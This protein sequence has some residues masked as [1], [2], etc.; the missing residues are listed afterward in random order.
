MWSENSAGRAV[1]LLA[2]P[3]GPTAE[4]KLRPTL[5]L[6]WIRGSR[7]PSLGVGVMA[8]ASRNGD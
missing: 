2:G 5:R 7:A 8:P 3:E 6:G 4:Q 1:F